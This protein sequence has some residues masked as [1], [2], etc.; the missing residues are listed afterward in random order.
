MGGKSK[1][2]TVGFRY[3]MDV[4][5]ALCHAGPGDDVELVELQFGER[6][7]WTGSVTE[8]QTISVVARDLFGGEDREG[9]V[10]GN[11]DVMM[12]EPT[13]SVN[14]FLGASMRASGITGPVP[15][16]RR[17]ISLFF[18][19]GATNAEFT[20]S[21][22]FSLITA[23]KALKNSI[24]TVT[25]PYIPPAFYWS[26]LNPYFK[27]PRARIR[28][29]FNGW[30]PEKSS[31]GVLAN[32]AHVIYECI[33]NS[34]WG[35]GYSSSDLDDT[36][37][38]AVADVLYT[39]GFGLG[40]TWSQSSRIEDFIESV[41]SHITAVLSEDRVTGKLFLKLI[42][43]DYDPETLIE[44]NPSNCVLESYDRPGI[45]E[46]VNEIVLKY[47][48]ADG[49]WDSV[50]VQSLA[51]IISQGQVISQSIEMPGIRNATLATRVAQRELDARVKPI[52]KLRITTSSIAY[53][54]YQGE[55]FKFSW[56]AHGIVAQY[57]RV[58]TMGVGGLDDGVIRIEAV[59][60][61]FGMPASSYAK[62]Q[63]VG[64]VDTSQNPVAVVNQSVREASY[65][66]VITE[67]AEADR[68]TFPDDFG[69][70]TILAARPQMDSNQY[71]IY[72]SPNTTDYVE[73]GT[74][75]WTPTATLT[76]GIGPLTTSFSVSGAQG[77]DQIS[78]GSL[79]YIGN[80][81]TEFV[82]YTAGT[83]VVKRGVA[84]TVPP[85]DGHAAGTRLWFMG[86]DLVGRDQDQKTAGEL[87]YYKAV[88]V[89]SRGSLA[90]TSA[91]AMSLVFANRYERPYPPGN[92]KISGVAYPTA[93]AG[94]VTVTWSHRDR[95]QQAN[96]LAG[97]TEGNI[98]PEVGT[99]YR[100]RVY[101]GLALIRTYSGITGTSQS[102]PVADAIADGLLASPRFV[103][104]SQRDALDSWMAHDLTI[105]R[106]NFI[107]AGPSSALD[108]HLAT[109]PGSP[110]NN[111]TYIV[112]A[113]AT[114]AWS[115]H[116]NEIARYS[117]SGTPGWV[118]FAPAEGWNIVIADEGV[119]STFTSG[120]WNAGVAV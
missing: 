95:L 41:L 82:S 47:R 49:K 120:A 91:P 96:V 53:S 112:P 32:P 84:D 60:D 100:L 106:T 5:A 103:L 14:S 72:N 15:A 59:E 118:F 85:A 83:L 23:P 65:Y 110:V 79:V 50:T 57:F 11:V 62:P 75:T 19:G 1:S 22:E 2:V 74:G 113:G 29:R 78:P 24:F 43:Q 73:I 71:R 21:P 119:L 16:Y 109:P 67:T 94:V 117:T 30:Y 90:V 114:G 40:F 69:F 48:T 77:V 26:A 86:E 93:V 61:I 17:V 3:Y 28:R 20:P 89:S 33:T 25:V 70:S 68:N 104:D 111:Q 108:R 51:S 13:L 102:Y 6:T 36:R 34:E 58:V 98:G 35:M 55:V 76:A 81:L 37:M 45:G 27:K 64:W 4:L 42:R 99:T 87:A 44:L 101:N 56:P 8:S 52:S 88:T 12:G 10:E 9:G 107:F 39:E 31:I 116:T 38:R 115:G 54:L 46:N 18:R 92:F 66:E 97:T 105:T 63:P 7:A 80:E